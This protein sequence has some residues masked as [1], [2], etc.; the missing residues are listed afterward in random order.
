[1]FL[2]K[3]EAIQMYRLQICLWQGLLDVRFLQVSLS[4]L[5]SKGSQEKRIAKG[6]IADT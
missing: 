1:M 4:N 3:E 6:V 5:M 2:A